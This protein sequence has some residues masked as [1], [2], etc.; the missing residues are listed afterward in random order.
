MISEEIRG[1][2]SKMGAL[3]TADK[4]VPLEETGTSYQRA[5]CWD[6]SVPRTTSATQSSKE[7]QY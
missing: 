4:I 5:K 6:C 1:L 7:E 3:E 2:D